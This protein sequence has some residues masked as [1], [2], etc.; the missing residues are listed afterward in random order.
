MKGKIKN[1][2]FDIIQ[3]NI[4]PEKILKTKKIGVMVN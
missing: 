1:Q 3:T 2:A 4:I